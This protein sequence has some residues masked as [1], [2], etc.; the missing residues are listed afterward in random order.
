MQPLLSPLAVPVRVAYGLGAMAEGAK[1][2]LFSV[3]LLFYYHGVVGLD[4][5]LAGLALFLALC[6]D[7]V[8]DPLM[9]ALSDRWNSRWGRRHPFMALSVLPVVV[10]LYA[11]VQVPQ[12]LNQLGIFLWLLGFSILARQGMTLFAVPG[13]AMLPELCQGY[14]ERTE[15]VGLRFLF[16]WLAGLGVAIVGYVVYFQTPPGM[17]DGRLDPQAWPPFVGFAAA[18]AVCGIVISTVGTY[19]SW[20]QRAAPRSSTLQ[21]S[22]LWRDVRAVLALQA[23]RPLLWSALCSAAAWGYINATSLYVNTWFWGLSSQALGGLTISMVIAV[24]IAAA[25]AP[26]LSAATDKRQLALRLSQFALLFGPLAVGLKLLGWFPAQ[27]S[28]EAFALLFMHTLILFTALISISI[29]V[30][31]MLA[32]LADWSERQHGQ[33]HEGVFA[34]VMAF[35]IKATSGLGALLAGLVLALIGAD[36]T[37]AIAAGGAVEQAMPATNA[38]ALALALAGGIALLFTLSVVF[39]ARYPL[40]RAD[41]SRAA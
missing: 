18:V 22:L 1:D 37:T 9:G 30:A 2:T 23:F 11:L 3:F 14:D 39:L 33:R 25:A 36:P 21:W 27:G 6:L 40:R 35:V 38:N 7:A 17:P 31:S 26:G 16:G 29:L 8:S 20:Q 12:G 41:F 34:A 5:A 4:P 19:R 10:A 32:D 13:N 24:I 28:R 15:V